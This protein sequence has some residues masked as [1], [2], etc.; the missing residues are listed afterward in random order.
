MRG[1][2]YRVRHMSRLHLALFVFGLC[3]FGLG[4]G[5]VSTNGDVSRV[6]AITTTTFV[7]TTTT[8]QLTT[9]TT[10]S[11]ITRPKPTVVHQRAEIGTALSSARETTTT[12]TTESPKTPLEVAQSQ[13]GKTG[14][15]ADGGF[16]CAMFQSWLAEQAN[17]ED[18]E[19]SDSPARLYAV[20]KEQGRLTDAPQTGYLVF[21]DLTGENFANQYVSHVGIVESV[22]G[23]VIHTI[24]GNADGSGLVTR[25]TREIGDGYVIAFAPFEAAP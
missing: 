15:Y 9:T 8:T 16:W 14:P 10:T 24:E 6:S 13:V 21:I 5:I 3:L 20:A 19:Q 23:Q 7:P 1:A 4:I 18:F 11:D 2:H 25:Q 17:V 12:T 22:D